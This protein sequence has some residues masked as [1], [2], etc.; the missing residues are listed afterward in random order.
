M[1]RYPDTTLAD[2]EEK[3][4]A[5]HKSIAKGVDPSTERQDEKAQRQPTKQTLF[6]DGLKSGGR[7]G[8]KTKV[9]VVLSTLNVY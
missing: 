4:R 5:T 7:I 9:Y 2:A 8:M 6:S 1:G 3:V